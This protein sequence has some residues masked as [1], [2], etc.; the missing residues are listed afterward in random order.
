MKRFFSILLTISIVF[1]FI[2]VS[3]YS[4]S[5]KSKKFSVNKKKVSIK[6]GK[7]KTV[8]ITSKKGKKLT[9]YISNSKVCSVKFG[10]WK[11]KKITLKITGRNAGKAK[12]T[13]KNKKT[14]KKLKVKVTVTRDKTG[15]EK[16]RDYIN[17]KGAS[18]DGQ[19]VF[20]YENS[21]FEGAIYYNSSTKKFKFVYLCNDVARDTKTAAEMEMNISGNN[22]VKVHSVY[23]SHSIYFAFESD[24]IIYLSKFN[25][26]PNSAQNNSF[27]VS[28]DW[29][30]VS[31]SWENSNRIAETTRDAA[32]LV[33]L[34]A[35]AFWNLTLNKNPGLSFGDLGFK[36]IKKLSV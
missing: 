9:C 11:G 17:K 3:D 35:M 36:N 7:S 6:A 34:Q 30:N 18:V 27:S 21:G 15:L 29:D 13:I 24:A 1:S 8:K 32:K 26:Y 31:Y 19:K 25:L 16:L 28:T 12:L 4:V 14:K 10:K 23:V 22:S 5:A 33:T 20:Y 2:V